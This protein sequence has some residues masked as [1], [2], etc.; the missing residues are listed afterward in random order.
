MPCMG[1]YDNVSIVKLGLCVN[2]EL[3][4]YGSEIAVLM[5]LI[6]TMKNIFFN[7]EEYQNQYFPT[8]NIV[9]LKTER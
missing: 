9:L 3:N 8:T 6:I 1:S 5:K 7:F 4:T 2:K